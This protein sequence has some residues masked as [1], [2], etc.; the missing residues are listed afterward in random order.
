MNYT[1]IKKLPSI[2]NIIQSCPLSDAGHERIMHDR[3]EI[4]NILEGRDPRLLMIV[5]PCSAWPKDAVLEYASQLKVLNEQVKKS[6]K[7]VMRM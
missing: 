3:R 5:G 1:R 4:K 6:L 7:I 2:E